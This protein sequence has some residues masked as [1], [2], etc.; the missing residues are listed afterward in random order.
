MAKVSSIIWHQ[1]SENSLCFGEHWPLLLGVWQFGCAR[2]G[3]PFWLSEKSPS[4]EIADG[5]G[6]LWLIMMDMAGP[7]EGGGGVRLHP[8]HPP[9]L[10]V[11]RFCCCCCYRG[12]WC[13]KIPLPRVWKIDLKNVRRKKKC[14]SPPP[15]PPPPPLISF[16]RTCATFEAGGWPVKIRTPLFKKL[17]TGLDMGLCHVC[18]VPPLA[19]ATS[20]NTQPHP[21]PQHVSSPHQ[22]HPA[23]PIP[24]PIPLHVNK[25]ST[26][27]LWL[28]M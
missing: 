11:N 16:F 28:K 5:L 25:T 26:I 7:S 23:T 21:I 19:P 2:I 27:H 14:R 17:L 1:K 13:T 22:E 12:W 10:G 18:R 9:F 4:V 15:P 20:N 8:L 6:N 24:L 3:C